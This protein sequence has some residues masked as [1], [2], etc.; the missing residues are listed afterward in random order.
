MIEINED[1]RGQQ[2]KITVEYEGEI[3]SQNSDSITIDTG[4]DSESWALEIDFSSAANLNIEVIEPDYEQGDIVTDATG[5]DPR[6]WVFLP[7]QISHAAE[8]LKWLD[9]TPQNTGERYQRSELP[10][11]LRKI[12][13]M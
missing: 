13:L 3:I 8:S 2:V 5:V 4:S 6:R 9:I 10:K 1:Y 7:I 11:V 12:R